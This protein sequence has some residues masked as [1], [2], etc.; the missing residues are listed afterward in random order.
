MLAVVFSPFTPSRR[1]CMNSLTP[2]RNASG[3]LATQLT[4]SQTAQ[5]RSMDSDMP[6]IADLDMIHARKL[7]RNQHGSD[8]SIRANLV[9]RVREQIAAGT[10]EDPIKITV[11][12]DEL[13]REIKDQGPGV[14]QGPQCPTHQIP[15]IPMGCDSHYCSSC[16]QFVRPSSIFAE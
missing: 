14:L 2:G 10:Y 6:S 5:A 4:R 7:V 3:S 1:I 9:T 12:T 8:Q 11:A 16:M 13:I 15:L